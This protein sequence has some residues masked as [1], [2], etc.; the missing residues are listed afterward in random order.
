MDASALRVKRKSI[1]QPDA[2]LQLNKIK[3]IPLHISVMKLYLTQRQVSSGRISW[4][5]FF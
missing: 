1:E 5:F 2:K 3:C 4:W